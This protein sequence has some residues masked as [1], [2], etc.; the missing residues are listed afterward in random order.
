MEVP[1]LLGTEN[2]PFQGLRGWL[3]LV[4]LGL[5]V[6]FLRRVQTLFGT[7]QGY[8]SMAGWH[9]VTDPG[10]GSYHPLFGLYLMGEM[11]GNIVVIGLNVLAII[12]F[13]GK[14]RQFPRVYIAFLCSGFLLVFLSSL[15]ARIVR[16]PDEPQAGARVFGAF[17]AALLWSSYTLKS[18]RVKATF[19][20]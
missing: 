13:F 11:A 4:G 7:G 12:L 8:F 14:R 5:C 1:P 19:I 16:L 18:R 2:L 3:V 15:M 10:G 9:A 17:L 20:N 6:N